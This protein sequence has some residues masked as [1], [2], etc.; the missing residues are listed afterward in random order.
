[1]SVAQHKR[2]ETKLFFDD[3]KKKKKDDFDDLC[4]ENNDHH[5]LP[6]D[7]GGSTTRTRRKRKMSFL[8][9]D[10]EFIMAVHS[11][12]KMSKTAT[13]RAFA[14]LLERS[15]VMMINDFERMARCICVL[16]MSRTATELATRVAARIFAALV[17]ETRVVVSPKVGILV[18]RR[19][20]GG[21]GG[22][23]FFF[24]F[25]S[26]LLAD[27]ERVVLG[28][29]GPRDERRGGGGPPVFASFS[30]LFPLTFLPSVFYSQLFLD[31]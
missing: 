15:K 8:R 7:F 31:F 30:L 16:L 23:F 20:R 17:G 28:D 3:E 2:G 6:D 26:V 19:E 11:L 22:F 4:V 25:L 5:H 12:V 27:D 29:G 18:Q 24:F 21:G 1:M 14:S 10:F 13:E 9:A